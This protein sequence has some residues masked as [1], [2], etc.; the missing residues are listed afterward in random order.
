L[1][2]SSQA[3]LKLTG[4]YVQMR[5]VIGTTSLT[6]RWPVYYPACKLAQCN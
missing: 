5:E 4:D 3:A 2:A 1:P 6:T